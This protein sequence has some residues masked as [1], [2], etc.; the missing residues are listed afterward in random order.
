MSIPNEFLDLLQ[1]WIRGKKNIYI[2]VHNGEFTHPS[3][4]A[5]IEKMEL[6]SEYFR[7]NTCIR[8]LEKKR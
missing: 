1:Q 5:R 3:S 8:V 6:K 7:E 4:N 2:T